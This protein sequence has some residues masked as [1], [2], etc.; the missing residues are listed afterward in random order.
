M[1]YQCEK[2]GADKCKLWRPLSCFQVELICWTCLESKGHV[3]ELGKPHGSDQVYNRDIEADCWGPAVPDLDGSWW[4][5]TSVPN[6]WVA[7]WKALPNKK[8]DCTVCNGE[9]KLGGK[10]DCCYCDGTGQREKSAAPM[11]ERKIDD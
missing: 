4:G 1:T 10:Y 7:W 5:Y 11:S 8:T 2:C 9:G 6:W 3:V